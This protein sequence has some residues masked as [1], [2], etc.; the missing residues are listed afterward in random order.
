M[1]SHPLFQYVRV[2][3]ECCRTPQD[4]WFTSADDPVVCKSCTVHHKGAPTWRAREHLG[5]Y[6]SELMVSLEDREF[7]LR[8][9]QA[10][11]QRVEDR[12]KQ[13]VERMETELSAQRVELFDLRAAVR[14]GE[15]NSA[16]HKW[17]VDEEVIAAKA[18]RDRA[19]RWRDLAFAALW[20]VSQVHRPDPQDDHKCI[21]GRKESKC[22]ELEAIYPELRALGEWEDKQVERLLQ[23]LE[24]GLPRAHPE[25][26]RRGGAYL[27]RG[28]VN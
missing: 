11:L 18:S 21:C 10:E 16:V 9:H 12:H 24:H 17:M 14:D 5:L 23:D 7:E 1:H 19:Y 15:P 20:S 28:N 4:I 22:R 2:E 25:V 8:R 27:R 26:M 3:C 13:T 6:H